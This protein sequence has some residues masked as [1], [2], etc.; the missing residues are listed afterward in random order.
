[1]TA[2]TVSRLCSL[3]FSA[4]LLIAP[5]H[6]GESTSPD[7]DQSNTENAPTNAGGF[8][9]SPGMVS[10]YS[11]I[12]PGAGQLVNG[13]VAEGIGQYAAASLLAQQATKYSEKADFLGSQALTYTDRQGVR[14]DYT[15]ENTFL[16]NSASRFSLNLMFY[17]SYAAM[18]DRYR[19][20]GIRTLNHAVSAPQNDF[21]EL[22]L[23]PFEWSELSK[24]EVWIPIAIASLGLVQGSEY[25]IRAPNISQNFYAATAITS[26]AYTTAIGEEVFFRGVANTQLSAAWGENWGLAG[27]SI[28]FGLAHNG[29]GGS[30][31]ALQAAA[32]GAYLGWVHQQNHYDLKATTALHFWWNTLAL[33]S[34]IK[35]SSFGQ[36][37]VSVKWG[38]SF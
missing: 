6:A 1:M 31:N 2:I 20:L 7:S 10:L 38:F 22:A 11:F 17:S 35:D 34:A 25:K 18:R 32:F 26:S 21:N 9:R 37:Q 8:L 23:A 36:Q 13:D 3:I 15:N 19:Q 5:A 12:I 4:T 16:Y 24:N 27:S 30:A 14:Y 33:L 29:A 28:V